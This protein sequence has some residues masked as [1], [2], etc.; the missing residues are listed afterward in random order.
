MK[1]RE[2]HRLSKLRAAAAAAAR[3]HE[4]LKR[5]LANRDRA[6]LV[7]QRT[8]EVARAAVA[9]RAEAERQRRRADEM[10]AAAVVRAA[11]GMTAPAATQALSPKAASAVAPEQRRLSHDVRRGAWQRCS[12][13]QFLRPLG[14]VS[15][16][17]DDDEDDN[18]NTKRRKTLAE[19]KKAK[20]LVGLNANGVE[21]GG[22]AIAT[23][24]LG[25]VIDLEV[26]N[27]REL[28][29]R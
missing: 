3:M 22:D 9:T 4:A 14:N 8:A 25:D 20:R 23:P 6:A 26:A 21:S 17:S 29:K 5:E 13:P 12:P 2:L 16:S 7:R 18:D 11:L 27:M 19:W 15:T 24:R 28:V 1:E 10:E